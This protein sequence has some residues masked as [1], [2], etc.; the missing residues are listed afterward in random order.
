[1][2]VPAVTVQGR[3]DSRQLADTKMLGQDRR[4]LDQRAMDD[5]DELRRDRTCRPRCTDDELA[6]AKGVAIVSVPYSCV[7]VPPA[8]Q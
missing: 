2:I 8:F 5:L 3:H 7:L 1:M 6:R 4:R